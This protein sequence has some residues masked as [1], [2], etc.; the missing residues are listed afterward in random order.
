VWGRRRGAISA[1]AECVHEEGGKREE[2]RRVRGDLSS[3]FRLFSTPFLLPG[4]SPPV[5]A[6]TA[7][8]STL[9]RTADPHH[10]V[11]ARYMPLAGEV[12]PT[13]TGVNE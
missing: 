13:R 11:A 8:L 12:C 6:V 3:L 9:D 1:A 4:P 7:H 5:A 10:L 2:G